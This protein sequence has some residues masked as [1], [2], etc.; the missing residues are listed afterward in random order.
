[1]SSF[2][3]CTQHRGWAN[4][5]LPGVS[6]PKP[7]QKLKNAEPPGILTQLTKNRHHMS[8]KD[9]N[10]QEVNLRS[11]CQPQ[12]ITYLKMLQLI[13]ILQEL[14]SPTAAVITNK[15]EICKSGAQSHCKTK[16]YI[17][18]V[19]KKNESH[20]GLYFTS[21]NMCEWILVL[22]SLFTSPN[23]IRGV[24]GRIGSFIQFSASCSWWNCSLPTLKPFR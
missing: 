7:K 20:H 13:S 8:G 15:A 1:M 4:I 5:S 2:H 12:R 18:V 23:Q 9:L 6:L 10:Y 14:M 24:K 3:H 17:Y 21:Y 16:I 11:G 22:Y 19:T